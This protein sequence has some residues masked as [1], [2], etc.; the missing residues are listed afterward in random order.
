MQCSFSNGC[1]G[2]EIAMNA[3]DVPVLVFTG[4]IAYLIGAGLER[5][6]SDAELR[7]LVYK[8]RIIR[9]KHAIKK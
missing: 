8:Y 2:R 4:V 9:M 3:S 7:S 6:K 1:T 5:Q